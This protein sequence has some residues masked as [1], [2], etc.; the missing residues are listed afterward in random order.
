MKEL[1]EDAARLKEEARRREQDLKQ[2]ITDIERSIES[3]GGNRPAP[4]YIREVVD[5]MQKNFGDKK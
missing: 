1:Q 2:A 4:K 3:K 5:K